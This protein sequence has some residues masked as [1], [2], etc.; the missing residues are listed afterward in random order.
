MTV[1]VLQNH[2]GGAYV[3]AQS[4]EAFATL[5]PATG[6]VLARVEI[7][8]PA[9]VERAVE[10]ARRGQAVW[11]AMTGAERGRILRRVAD[12]LRRRNDELAELET[13]DTG[14]PIQ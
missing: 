8:G 13:R 5:N 1:P 14:K 7:A 11:A 3:A 9:E 6:E 12:L 10:V 4:G 2:I